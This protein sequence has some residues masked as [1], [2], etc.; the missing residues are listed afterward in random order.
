MNEKLKNLLWVMKANVILTLSWK[1]VG[2]Y[3]LISFEC[4][5]YESENLANVQRCAECIKDKP[6]YE[7]TLLFAFDWASNIN[8]DANAVIGAY[9]ND[10]NSQFFHELIDDLWV[11]YLRDGEDFFK[12]DYGIIRTKITAKK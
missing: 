1:T 6:F 2:R 4:G 11:Y 3:Y 10:P 8:A 5:S 7:R 12:P 9:I